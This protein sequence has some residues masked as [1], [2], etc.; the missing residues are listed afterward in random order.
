MLEAAWK[1]E[2]W[3]GKIVKLV[4]DTTNTDNVNYEEAKK[5]LPIARLENHYSENNVFLPEGYLLNPNNLKKIQHIPTVIVQGRYDVCCPPASAYQLHK[6][7]PNSKI[8]FTLTGHSAN[9]PEVTHYLVS[10]TEQFK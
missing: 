9:E 7:L 3:E 10:A 8:N 4:Q 1:W 6:N 5:M 2:T